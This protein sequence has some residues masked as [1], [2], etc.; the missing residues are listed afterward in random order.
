MIKVRMNKA[1]NGDCITLQTE[2]HFVMIDGGTAQSFDEWKNQIIGIVDK[3]DTLIITHIDND[4]VNGIVK[5]LMDDR[6]PEIGQVYFN[7]VEQLLGN[8][9]IHEEE[10]KIERSLRALAT[11]CS[12]IDS[13]VQIGF[14]EGTSL[15]Y[16]LNEKKLTCNAIVGG[17][18]I[19]R[20]SYRILLW[21]FKI[22]SYWS[23]F[24]KFTRVK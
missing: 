13:T 5:L 17:Q 11:E 15:S 7:G 23:N 4:H 21:G 22:Q 9:E 24:T 19:C 2:N 1:G 18:A 8:F 6:C 10:P 14:S 3:I 16:L 20:E 12:T